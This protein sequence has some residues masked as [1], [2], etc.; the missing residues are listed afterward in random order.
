[1]ITNF[2]CIISLSSMAVLM[3]SQITLW[4]WDRRT[5]YFYKLSLFILSKHFRWNIIFML[6]CK[7]EYDRNY[8]YCFLIHGLINFSY[9]VS[10]WNDFNWELFWPLICF[11]FPN[12]QLLVDVRAEPNL[13]VAYGKAGLLNSLGLWFT[14]I[15]FNGVY[16]LFF[17]IYKHT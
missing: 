2:F 12:V 14:Y 4:C 3:M 13:L 6:I 8:I 11:P 10:S 7:Q 9:S 16:H 17:L 5:M 1:M 15:L